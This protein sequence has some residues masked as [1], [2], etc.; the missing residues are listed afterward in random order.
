[1]LRTTWIC[2][3]EGER[4][5]HVRRDPP[6]T[7]TVESATEEGLV[8]TIPPVKSAID[9]GE[10]PARG[11]A[12]CIVGGVKRV[13]GGAGT[14]G[15]SRRAGVAARTI[16]CILSGRIDCDGLCQTS[17][18]GRWRFSMSLD[19]EVRPLFYCFQ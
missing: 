1:M 8:G 7:R 19:A 9:I 11:S 3:T 14:S 18:E 12:T 2:S 5:D 6:C 4:Y 15:D 10:V 17:G 16:A 13:D